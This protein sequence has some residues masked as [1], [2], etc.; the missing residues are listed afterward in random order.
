MLDDE[1]NKA[2]V[3]LRSLTMV[4]E[5]ALDSGDGVEF[6]LDGSVEDAELMKTEQIVLRVRSAASGQVVFATSMDRCGI[7]VLPAGPFRLRVNLEMNVRTGVF[8]VE[9]YV[10]L[11]QTG[12]DVA[13]GPVAYVQVKEDPG[14][15][16]TVQLKPRMRLEPLPQGEPAPTR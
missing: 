9:P 10:V 2:A 4:G 5:V 15:F 14:S 3:R 11:R 7:E 13:A 12:K 6:T 16:G 1:H 8:T